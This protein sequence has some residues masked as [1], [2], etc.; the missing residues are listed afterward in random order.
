MIITIMIHVTNKIIQKKEPGK[1]VRS[2]YEFFVHV[3]TK[4]NVVKMKR[5]LTV[6]CRDVGSS[7]DL[8]S[9]V[10]RG[11]SSPSMCLHRQSEI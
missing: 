5:Q 8:Q 3:F 11:N 9:N 10:V 7:C 4:K 6:S 2:N 1:Y